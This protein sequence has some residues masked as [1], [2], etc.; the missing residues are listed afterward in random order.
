MG[1]RPLAFWDCGFE[2]GQWHG[3]LSC[4]R[5]VLSRRVLCTGLIT[6]AE[7]TYRGRFVW[8]LS[9]SLDNDKA[10]AQ[11]GLLRRGGKNYSKELNGRKHLENLSVKSM[12]ITNDILGEKEWEE[13]VW[14]NFTQA[15]RER[16]NFL[17]VR[18]KLTVIK[19]LG[20]FLTRII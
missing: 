18:I 11:Y 20:D 17:N 6:R 4:E 13:V 19:K 9:W 7:K 10:L 8:A 16:C 5:C 3:C 12:I 14:I 2:F 15:S 1:L